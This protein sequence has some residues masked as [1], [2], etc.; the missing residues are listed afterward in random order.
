MKESNLLYLFVAVF[1]VL[2]WMIV[3]SIIKYSQ[4]DASVLSS[5]TSFVICVLIFVVVYFTV[6]RREKEALAN[7][8]E[9]E[10]K[11]Q[12]EHKRIQN[13]A[14]SFDTTVAQHNAGYEK[15]SK[16]FYTDYEIFAALK[17]YSMILVYQ[18]SLGKLRRG[19]K[20]EAL[21]QIEN[22]EETMKRIVNDPLKEMEKIHIDLSGKRIAFESLLAKWEKRFEHPIR[23]YHCICGQDL[24]CKFCNEPVFKEDVKSRI[25]K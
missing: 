16:R 5:M 24:T 22:A 25:S 10:K 1:S 21:K 6:E 4:N 14:N 15:F 19:Q 23:L 3:F 11:L 9:C 13:A 8:A 7:I 17:S 12:T 18:S 2:I 20:E